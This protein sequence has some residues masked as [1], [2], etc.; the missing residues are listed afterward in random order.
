MEAGSTSDD[1]PEQTGE[2]MIS[3]ASGA[4]TCGLETVTLMDFACCSDP[5]VRRHRELLFQLLPSH[6]SGDVDVKAFEGSR[7]KRTTSRGVRV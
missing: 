1:G 3:S 4:M 5:S 7:L 2:L 6:V